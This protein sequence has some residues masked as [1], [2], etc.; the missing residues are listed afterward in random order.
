MS[1]RFEVAPVSSI[2]TKS[3]GSP[4]SEPNGSTSCAGPSTTAATL[5]SPPGGGARFT[6]FPL[7]SLADKLDERRRPDRPV[8]EQRAGRDQRERRDPVDVSVRPRAR[9]RDGIEPE[10]DGDQPRAEERFLPESG[11]G[12]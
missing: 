3:G 6:R 5:D 8:E 10:R 2:A 1:S 12:W 11:P 7:P 9:T 4:V